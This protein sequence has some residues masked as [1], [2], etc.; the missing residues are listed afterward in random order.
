MARIAP[1]DKHAAMWTGVDMVAD[2]RWGYVAGSAIINGITEAI[3]CHDCQWEPG[4]AV[5]KALRSVGDPTERGPSNMGIGPGTYRIPGV[6]DIVMEVT[7]MKP[8]KVKKEKNVAKE[9]AP[10]KQTRRRRT[11]IVFRMFGNKIEVAVYFIGGTIEDVLAL[12]EA[13]RTA[14]FDLLTSIKLEQPHA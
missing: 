4:L 8:E 9:T 3:V 10:K 11:P 12:P 6:E 1:C 2:M 5:E 13:E 14:L 7:R